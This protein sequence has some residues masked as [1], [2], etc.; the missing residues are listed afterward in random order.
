MAEFRSESVDDLIANF[1]EEQFVRA[2]ECM[3]RRARETATGATAAAPHRSIGMFMPST[4]PELRGRDNLPTFLQ[5]FR[6]WASI[7]GCDSAQCS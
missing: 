1:S 5:R 3:E 4:V 2:Q 6:T 7:S